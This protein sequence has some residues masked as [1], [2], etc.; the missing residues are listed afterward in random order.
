QQF[1]RRLVIAVHPAHP[2]E[3]EVDG[4]LLAMLRRELMNVQSMEPEVSYVFHH[5]TIQ[6]VTY[7]QLPVAQ[8]RALHGA[9]AKWYEEVMGHAPSYYP[10]LAYHWG[11]GE[12]PDKE[13]EYLEK[14]GAE[15][16]RNFANHEA[17]SCY[18]SALDRHAQ[19]FGDAPADEQRRRRAHWEC[20]LG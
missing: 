18:R 20:Q 19:V 10:L 3:G 6:Q 1:A 8:R 11:R 15:A 7:D 14:S 4:H 16:L 17:A 12:V 5:T 2:G 13:L 9:V